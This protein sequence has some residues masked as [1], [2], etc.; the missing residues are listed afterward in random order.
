MTVEKLEMKLRQEVENVAGQV[1]KLESLGGHTGSVDLVIVLR[2]G[3]VG[4]VRL[5]EPD[6]RLN[7][8]SGS[9]IYKLRERGC[10][11]CAVSREDEV[12]RVIMYI[13]SDAGADPCWQMFQ[14]QEKRKKEEQL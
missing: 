9:S 4:F 1:F 14:M 6:E 2:G 8:K 7:L 11:A 10:T 13:L 3:H 12:Q 5:R